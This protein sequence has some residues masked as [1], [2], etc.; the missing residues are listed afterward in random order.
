MVGRPLSMGCALLA[1]LGQAVFACGDSNAPSPFDALDAGEAGAPADSGSDADVDAGHDSTL[2]GPCTDVAQCDDGVDCTADRCDLEIERCRFEP[3][4]SV[5]ADEVYCDGDE[6]CEPGLGCREGEPVACSD[7]DSCSIDRCDEATQSCEHVERDAD[8]DGD[9]VWNCDGG[10]CDD[11]DP[12]ISSAAQE[13]CGNGHDDDCDGELDE[14]DCV[15]PAYD[16]CLDALEITASGSYSLPLAGTNRDYPLSCQGGDD[17]W[18]DGV[19]AVIVP[20]GEPLDVDL[21]AT[22][23]GADLVLGNAE[24]CGDASSEA[25]CSLNYEAESGGSVSRLRLRGLAPGAHA[26]YVSANAEAEVGLR[27]RFE[28]ATT[29]PANETC[30][31]AA[32]LEPEQHLALALVGLEPDVTSACP[33]NVGELVYAFELAETQDVTLRAISLDDFGLP[34]ISLRSATCKGLASELTCRHASP[35]ELYA[36]ALP[37][38]QY[39]A[40]VSATAPIDVDLVLELDAPS[41]ALPGEGCDDPATLG[42]E[43]TDVDFLGRVDAVKI[44]CLIGAPDASYA[45]NLDQASDVLLVARLS[46]GDEGSVLFARA[47]CDGESDV[48]ACEA[49]TRTPLRSAAHGVAAGNYRAIVESAGAK[50]MSLDVFRR[51]ATAATYV[52]FA[53]ECVSAIAIPSSGGLFQGNTANQYA[54]YDAGCDSASAGPGG[55]PD[56]MLKLELSGERRV[57]L[58]MSGSEYKTLLSVRR[59]PDCPGNEVTLGCSASDGK[60]PSFLDLTLEAGT[61]YVQIDGVDGASGRWQLDAF[62]LATAP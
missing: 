16:V 53:D 5:C 62:V 58:D 32:V 21:T 14:A 39:F 61:Y 27:V 3:D 1:L 11:T 43:S 4:D 34:V 57:I 25:A 15:R 23:N 35:A 24:Q 7:G 29:A 59:G 60:A 20:E 6:R 54:D 30:G 28:P 42:S 17:P 22:A 36:R 37:A 46:D 10:D 56:Q 31:T 8:G 50:P 12:N 55:A 40:T 44:G 41:E 2:G 49:S 52:A 45:L 48:M 18:H 38:G 19:V 33:A 13:R 51:P 26:I 9:P 47:A